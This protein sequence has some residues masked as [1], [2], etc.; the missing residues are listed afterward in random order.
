MTAK[1]SKDGKGETESRGESRKDE[2]AFEKALARLEKIVAE[3]EAGKLPL[4]EMIGRFEEGQTLIKFCT[5]KLNEVE[6]RIE[7]LVKK[8]EDV[9]AEPF[10]E[11]P[12]A[13]TGENDGDKDEKD[14]P[15]ELF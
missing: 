15:T 5:K 10:D 3:M 1:S 12:E 11:S 7:I 2:P 8:G 6:R 4:E 13:E 14:G 9:A